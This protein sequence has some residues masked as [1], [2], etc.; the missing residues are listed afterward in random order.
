MD[1]TTIDRVKLEAIKTDLDTDDDLLALLVTGASRAIDRKVTGAAFN[2]AIDYFEQADVSGELLNGRINRDGNVICA[3]H[4][5]VVNSI[6]SFEYRVSPLDN[7]STISTTVADGQFAIGWLQGA[8]NT[9]TRTVVR[10]PG[11]AFVRIS[12]NGG[13]AEDVDNLPADL[14]ELATLLCAR[15][16]REAET[17]LTDAIGVAELGVLIYTKAWPVRFLGMLE[18]FMRRVGWSRLT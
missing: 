3:P 14:I 5:P 12:Y 11:P 6:A 15:F 9:S 1:Y 7:W 2:D 17:G 10:I 8:V 16:Y 13:L 4:K 18:P